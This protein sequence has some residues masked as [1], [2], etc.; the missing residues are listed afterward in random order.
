MNVRNQ[1]IAAS[2]INHGNWDRILQA[3][4][5]NTLPPEKEAD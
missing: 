4:E 5:T 1:I 3:V 2:I